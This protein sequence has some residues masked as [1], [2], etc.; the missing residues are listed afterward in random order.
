MTT[1]G[2]SETA[3]AGL[4]GSHYAGLQGSHKTY[5]GLQSAGDI[6]V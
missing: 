2:H 1:A 5:G 6:A 4:D 3:Y